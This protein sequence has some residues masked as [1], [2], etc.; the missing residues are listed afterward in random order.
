MSTPEPIEVLSPVPPFKAMARPLTP[1][2][3][4]L[5]GLRIGFLDNT[6]HNA[7]LLFRR[8]GEILQERYGVG[9]VVHRR[10]SASSLPAPPA[11]ISDLVHNCDLV[12]AGSAD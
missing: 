2:P 4:R 7:G 11:M 1:R 12:V 5:E 9:E 3:E 6:K 10:K 8:L